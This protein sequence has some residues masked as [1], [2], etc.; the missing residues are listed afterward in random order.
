VS[1]AAAAVEATAPPS[2]DLLEQL[3][4]EHGRPLRRVAKGLSLLPLGAI[5]AFQRTRFRR[6][7]VY[8]VAAQVIS[9]FVLRLSSILLAI[10][11]LWLTRFAISLL[12][13]EGNYTRLR[14]LAS[15]TS[16]IGIVDGFIAGTPFL[17]LLSLRY[18]WPAKLDQVFMD[19]VETRDRALSVVLAARPY[20]YRYWQEFRHYLTRS[21]G[22]LRWLVAMRLIMLIPWVGS[23]LLMGFSFYMA[24]RS[25]GRRLAFVYAALTLLPGGRFYATKLMEL[26][27]GSRQLVRELLEPFFCRMD[28]DARMRREWF[29]HRNAATF[30]FGV[31]AYILMQQSWTNLLVYIMAQ[32]AIVELISTRQVLSYKPK[33]L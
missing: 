3:F 23:L 2:P 19:S 29:R 24:R 18:V 8:A 10:G 11:P 15:L 7:F 14:L 16:L 13:P 21:M 26:T 32:A 28:M 12:L 31:L 20:T 33:D 27:L 1:A 25:F 9:F 4:K 30:G 5:R 17:I 6:Q 22:R